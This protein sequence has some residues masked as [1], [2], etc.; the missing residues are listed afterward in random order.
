MCKV[1]EGNK[2]S[3]EYEDGYK[4]AATGKAWSDC[5]YPLIVV[6]G[7][8][9]CSQQRTDWIEGFGQWVREDNARQAGIAP[10]RYIDVLYQDRN[11]TQI[12]I[13]P[14]MLEEFRLMARRAMNT[15]QDPS[16]EMRDF[17]DRLMGQDTLMAS[18]KKGTSNVNDTDK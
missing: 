15:W 8:K 4:A 3:K 14:T 13:P 1:E 10:S 12:E 11:W 9:K 6:F 17:Y 5:P 18:T 2:D 7:V 16:P